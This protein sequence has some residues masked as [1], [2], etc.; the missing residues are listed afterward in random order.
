M[1][2][3]DAAGQ[4]FI[5][6][7]DL[8]WMAD[9]SKELRARLGERASKVPTRALPDFVLRVAAVFDAAL[10]N[11]APLLGR[12]FAFSSAK[13]QRVLGW[14]LRPGATTVVDC[15]ESLIAGAQAAI[16]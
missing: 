12:K 15:A 3:P 8:M 13:A 9:I 2:V 10:K 14:A 1:A 5:V 11:I 6:V 16:P 7:R 4:R